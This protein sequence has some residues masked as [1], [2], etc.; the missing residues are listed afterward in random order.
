MNHQL[1]SF[2]IAAA[3]ILLSNLASFILGYNRGS[4]SCSAKIVK[5]IEPLSEALKQRTGYT[6]SSGALKTACE[7]H[8][9]DYVLMPN[10]PVNFQQ[11]TRCLLIKTMNFVEPT[12]PWPQ[13]A[14]EPD[15]C[16]RCDDPF[17]SVNEVYTTRLGTICAECNREVMMNTVTPSTPWPQQ[18]PQ[19]FDP[20]TLPNNLRC[21]MGHKFVESV[22]MNEHSGKVVYCE[23]CGFLKP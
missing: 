23:R 22:P 17:T 11:C 6:P 13:G 1:N 7:I 19:P 14:Q 5:M 18:G 20:S 4:V 10:Q 21:G 9:H 16:A 8:G 2:T 3:F 12:K 15:R